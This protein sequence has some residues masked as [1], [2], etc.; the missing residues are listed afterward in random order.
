MLLVFAVVQPA[1]HLISLARLGTVTELN[2]SGSAI[3]HMRTAKVAQVLLCETMSDATMPVILPEL[4]SCFR[5]HVQFRS[6]ATS[7]LCLP[8]SKWAWLNFMYN[9]LQA[10]EDILNLSECC[11]PSYVHHDRAGCAWH[12]Q[13]LEGPL[14][15]AAPSRGQ[16]SRL[17]FRHLCVVVVGWHT[18]PLFYANQPT[19]GPWLGMYIR[20]MERMASFRLHLV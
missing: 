11:Q 12:V 19:D 10:D 17:Y 4:S 1:A 20:P 16:A 8:Y 2:C 9:M 6:I 13:H 5:I 15:P 3:W 7:G 18:A 14:L